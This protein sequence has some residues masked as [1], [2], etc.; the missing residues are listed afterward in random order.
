M[1][2]RLLSIPL[3]RRGCGTDGFR[4]IPAASLRRLTDKFAHAHVKAD[5]LGDVT[6]AVMNRFISDRI[7]ENAWSAKTAND[8]REVLHRLFAF[9]IQHHGFCSWER[10]YPS[11]VTAV[12]RQTRIGAGISRDR[13]VRDGCDAVAEVSGERPCHDTKAG[14]AVIADGDP[15]DT[16]VVVG[17]G[18]V[19][20]DI[21][22]F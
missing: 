5:L 4:R 3:D 15:H 11:P 14:P 13:F 17:I 21:H 22:S 18:Q 16:R 12:E 9:L 6:P 8:F 20:V 7:R 10:R 19:V 2:P 1:P